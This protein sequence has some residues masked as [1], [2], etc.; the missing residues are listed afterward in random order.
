MQETSEVVDRLLAD[1]SDLPSIPAVALE[2]VRLTEDESCTIERFAEVLSRDPALASKVL[3]FANSSLYGLHTPASNLQSATMTL[4]TRAV[5][6]MA[7]SFSL[8]S[9]LPS[10]PTGAFDRRQYWRRSLFCAVAAR[11]LA[12]RAGSPLTEEAFLCGLLS[13]IGQLVLGHCRPDLYAKLGNAPGRA[14]PPPRQERQVL[15]FDGY[16]LGAA[17]LRRWSLPPFLCDAVGAAAAPDG[18]PD[19]AAPGAKQLASLLHAAVLCEELVC[20]EAGEPPPAELAA[21]IRDA[22]GLDGEALEG[23]LGELEPAIGETARMLEVEIDAAHTAAIIAEAQRLLLNESLGIASEAQQARQHAARLEIHNRRLSDQAH[24]DALTGLDNRAAFDAT[25]ARW[26]CLPDAHDPEHGVGLVLIDVDH[27]KAFN[28]RYGHPTGDEVLRV[29]G[30]AIRRS[31]R[32]D[33]IAARY[34]G[35]EFAVILPRVGAAGLATVAE[36]IRGSIEQARLETRGQAISV[37]ASLGGALAAETSGSD[38]AAEL[39]ERA[40]RRL[41]EAKDAGR[42]TCRTAPAGKTP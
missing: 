10:A 29:I 19:D 27:F 8:A 9:S 35:E 39:L 15:G 2:I 4:G 24:T 21:R 14:W 11:S 5:K 36:R 25:L 23:F 28:D 7:L 42:N 32:G 40:D 30:R 37:T 18:L 33:E 26:L 16:E 41:Y 13:R 12:E 31:I 6:L 17:L 34:G 38:A 20:G 22:H 3:R 1:V